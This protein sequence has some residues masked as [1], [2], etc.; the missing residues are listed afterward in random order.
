MNKLVIPTI[1]AF[2]VIIAGAFAF[3]PVNKAETVHTQIIETAGIEVLVERAVVLDKDGTDVA[4]TFTAA[5]TGQGVL[6]KAIYTDNTPTCVPIANPQGS[7]FVCSFEVA[8]EPICTLTSFEDEFDETVT[9]TDDDIRY[10]RFDC[11]DSGFDILQ[12]KKIGSD[13]IETSFMGGNSLPNNVPGTSS[14]EDQLF[15]FNILAQ[16][17]KQS[18]TVLLAPGEQ[19]QVILDS[20]CGSD[21]DNDTIIDYL[22]GVQGSGTLTATT[23]S[24]TAE[25]T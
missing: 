12:I 25:C 11:E 1:L 3:M 16:R 22:I 5:A 9:H 2:T 6:I 17:L 7:D 19:F 13:G 14:G 15:Y 21:G 20:R 18:E 10:T 4:F 23:V 24:G 8:N